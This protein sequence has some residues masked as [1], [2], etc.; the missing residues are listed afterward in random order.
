LAG[1]AL[2]SPLVM[3]WTHSEWAVSHTGVAP[4]QFPLLVHP[5]RQTKK[6]GSHTGRAVPQSELLM[7]STHWFVA[8]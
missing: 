1:S 2:Q 4:E 5:A 7:H 6:W 8:R 3:H